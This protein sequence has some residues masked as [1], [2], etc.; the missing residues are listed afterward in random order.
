MGIIR[1]QIAKQAKLFKKL[2]F[3][4]GTLTRSTPG[5]RAAGNLSGGTQPTTASYTCVA[6]VEKK[7]MFSSGT[8][9]QEGRSIM[10]FLGGKISVAPKAGDVVSLGGVT[11]RVWRMETDPDEAVYECEVSH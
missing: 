10:T 9:V 8:L 3:A 1:K 4:S 5:T 6:M 7:S 2:G 11:Y